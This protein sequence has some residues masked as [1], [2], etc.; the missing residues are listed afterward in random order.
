MIQKLKDGHRNKYNTK[1]EIKGVKIKE[2]HSIIEDA[3]RLDRNEIKTIRQRLDELKDIV[4]S[5]I[6]PNPSQ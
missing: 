4:K 2:A 1:Q 6:P 3:H 5:V